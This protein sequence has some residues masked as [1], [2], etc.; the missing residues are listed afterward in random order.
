MFRKLP[1]SLL[2]VSDKSRTLDPVLEIDACCLVSSLDAQQQDAHCT[3]F[4]Q[5]DAVGLPLLVSLNRQPFKVHIHVRVNCDC[6]ERQ[7]F[8]EKHCTI[9]EVGVG[10]GT[11]RVYNCRIH[12][13]LR[14]LQPVDLA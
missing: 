9:E 3:P 1:W 7:Q 12:P 2:I 14:M 11:S 4:I 8:F 5:T 6:V 13:R 10:R